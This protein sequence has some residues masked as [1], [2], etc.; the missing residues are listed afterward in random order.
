MALS[1]ETCQFFKIFLEQ[2]FVRLIWHLLEQEK[3][4]SC[5]LK[6]NI[7]AST[8][9][10]LSTFISINISNFVRRQQNHRPW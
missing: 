2:V 10:T 1:K 6:S 8:I 9:G 4:F 3:S 7:K 5:I